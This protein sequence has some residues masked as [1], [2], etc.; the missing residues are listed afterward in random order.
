MYKY[1]FM[2]LLSLNILN[3]NSVK[4]SELELFLFKIGFESLLKDVDIN[5]DKSSLNKNEIKN[6]NEKIELIMSELYKDNRVLLNDSK[7]EISYNSTRKILRELKNEISYLKNEVK[8]LKEKK[9]MKSKIVTPLKK[10]KLAEK[11]IKKS[12]KKRFEHRNMRVATSFLAVYK[13]PNTQA[14]VIRKIK[15]ETLIQV[16]NCKN[17]WCKLSD[18]KSYVRRFLIKAY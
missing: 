8:K 14:E 18:N 13:L 7:E 17:G 2:L 15:R 3:A 11:N 16:K 9:I 4:T 10:E 5:K 6:I 12:L 1:I